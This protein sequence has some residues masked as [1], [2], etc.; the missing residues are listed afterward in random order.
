MKIL[1]LGRSGQLATA[2]S[3]MAGSMAE[4]RLQRVGRPDLDMAEPGQVAD[5]I[6][7]ERPD[8]V[9]NAVA[10][11]A[12]DK[13]EQE[14]GQ[15]FRLN[16]E[17]AGEAAE[18]A[19]RAGAGFI[20]VSTDYVFDGSGDR[21][22]SESD[23]TGPLGAYGRTKLAGEIEVRRRNPDALIVRT[24]WVYGPTGSNFVATM[25]RLG[26]TKDRITVVEDQVGCPTH[27]GDLAW[28][29]LTLARR[30]PEPAG[31]TLHVAGSGALSWADFARATFEAS[32][33]AGG[34][35]AEVIGIST[36]DYG[37]P[38]PRPANSR[39][40][41]ELLKSRFGLVVPGWRERIG[42]T[43]AKH[44][45]GMAPAACAGAGKP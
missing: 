21:P 39:L 34:P 44:L 16:A 13:A 45:A 26:A 1:V 41:T 18:A 22:W 11:T 17:A 14:E 2:L 36:A 6:A 5:L 15:A 29:L 38:A 30:W 28:V 20:H 42:P 3:E 8:L 32:A 7:A 40:S 43:V 37:A 25:L 24:S 12:V 23:P 4:V 35:S 10:Y 27:A 19:G 31:L 33:S 9:I